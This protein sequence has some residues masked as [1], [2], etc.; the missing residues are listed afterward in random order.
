MLKF[1]DPKLVMAAAAAI[2]AVGM[3]IFFILA[4]PAKA[5]PQ[6]PTPNTPW[7][8]ATAFAPW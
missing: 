6:A 4:P 2:I 3:A 1:I 8:R 5:Q 7:P